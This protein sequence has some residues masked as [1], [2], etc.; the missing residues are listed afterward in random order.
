MSERENQIKYQF[1]IDIC[2]A[3]SYYTNQICN[4]DK[5]AFCYRGANL[6]YAVERCLYI[7]CI[8]SENLKYYYIKKRKKQKIIYLKGLN[9]HENDLFRII[10]DR[11]NYKVKYK[12]FNS[13]LKKIAHIIRLLKFVFVRN[14]YS[15]D[16]QNQIIFNISNIK[17]INYLNPILKHL[18]K[19]TY[20]F[21]TGS[22]NNL[23]SF[24]KKNFFVLN[25]N[26]RY[27]FFKHIFSSTFLSDFLELL[28]DFDNNI[29]ELENNKPKCIVTIEGNA[30][31]DI[32][33]L[34]VAKKLEVPCYCIQQG[35]APLI[36]NGFRNMS[37]SEYF[38]WG[39]EFKNLLK[40]FNPKQKFLVTGSPFLSSKN[41]YIY[42]QELKTISFFLQD[43]SPLISKKAFL[44]FFDL[45]IQTSECFPEK[46]IIVKEHP[47]SKLDFYLKEKLLN[48]SN[49][50][51]YQ[52][53]SQKLNEILESSDITLSIF[54]SVILESLAKNKVPIICSF[55]CLPK[56]FPYLVEKKCALEVFT[57]KEALRTIN[58]FVENP[59]ELKLFQK[60]ILKI[61]KNLFEQTNA[62]KII[63]NR[64]S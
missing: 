12:Y 26:N 21:Q 38:V 50:T 11:K 39:K 55:S 48:L 40:E 15:Y 13:L 63:A 18:D 42:S 9:N 20:K 31:Q 28:K 52:S 8:N 49:I 32:I 7:Q 57:K 61:K 3:I 64:I 25:I 6:K 24:L 14:N 33:A 54:S 5:N 35:W 30:P 23:A 53:N 44:K 43:T 62:C 22:N 29:S 45:I 58:N 16:N 51:F 56:Y 60:N 41:S 46:S 47:S 10:F 17:F 34:E 19:N 59:E 36:H 4:I 1:Y 2:E 27:D 37:F